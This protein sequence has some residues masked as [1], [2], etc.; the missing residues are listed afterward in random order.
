M[1]K[2][3]LEKVDSMFSIFASIVII[4]AVVLAFSASY[5]ESLRA[6]GEAKFCNERNGVLLRSHEGTVCAKLEIVD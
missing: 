1:N 5:R 3:K 4:G 6:E 2:D